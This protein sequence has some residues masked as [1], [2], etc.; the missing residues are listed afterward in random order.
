MRGRHVR[1]CDHGIIACS[2]VTSRGPSLVRSTILS[3]WVAS[4]A[5][6]TAP[7]PV[8]LALTVTHYWIAVC[9]TLDGE[10]SGLVS[11]ALR[12]RLLAAADTAQRELDAF[13]N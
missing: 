4:S 5:R 3:G 13:P 7:C 10:R 8:C 12:L 1:G 9:A 2:S 11:E 6:A